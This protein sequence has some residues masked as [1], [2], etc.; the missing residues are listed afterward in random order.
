MIMINL[1]CPQNLTENL[2]E[3]K[4]TLENLAELSDLEIKEIIMERMIG[5]TNRFSIGEQASEM[6]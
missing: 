2:I 4:N 6:K 5:Q 1:N 3:T